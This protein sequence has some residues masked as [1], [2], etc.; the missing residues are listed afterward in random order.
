MSKIQKAL[1]KAKE[2]RDDIFD[3][4]MFVSKTSK[5]FEESLTQHRKDKREG[6]LAPVYL[7]TRKLPADFQHLKQNHIIPD[8]K[9]SA[10]ANRVK[11]LRT[12]ILNRMA[13]EGKNTLLITSANAGE[14]KTLTAINLAISISQE[15]DRT[16][17]LVDA[18]LRKPS[19][20]N[21]FGFEISEGL[22]DYL[23]KDMP[24]SDLLVSPGIEKLVILPGGKALTNSSELLGSPR[25]ESL[26][27]ELKERYSDLFIIFDSCSLLEYA[28][29]LVL[30]RFIDG[31]L[32]VV[33][34]EKTTKNDL[35]RTFELLKDKPV[36][37]TLL[38]KLRD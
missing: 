28:D 22:S 4:L 33:E 14:G 9:G 2:T 37:G 32:I 10:A 17:L 18:D 16:A 6:T 11:I 1:E 7:Q 20:H 30:S 13:K 15:I 35:K 31:I 25:M 8:C 36:I 26:V 5:D 38:N 34:A 24:L 3:N 12:K 19:I 29:P 23:K 27:K 21:F